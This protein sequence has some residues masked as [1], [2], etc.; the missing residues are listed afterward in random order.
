[1]QGPQYPFADLREVSPDS[2]VCLHMLYN[3]LTCQY[4]HDSFSQDAAG[5]DIE[6]DLAQNLRAYRF[7]IMSR[8]GRRA[9]VGPYNHF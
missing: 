6:S 2:K 8:P 1:M 7:L 3:Q 5:S 4:L 9:V